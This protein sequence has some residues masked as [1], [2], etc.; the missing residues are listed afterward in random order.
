MAA[1]LDSQ[2]DEHVLAHGRGQPAA[3]AVTGT[4]PG[5]FEPSS[6]PGDYARGA[7][8]RTH[9]RTNALISLRVNAGVAGIDQ[10]ATRA[11]RS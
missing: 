10:P 5:H 3:A 9:A 2:R 6:Q 8:T 4:Q 7:S 11:S 1:E